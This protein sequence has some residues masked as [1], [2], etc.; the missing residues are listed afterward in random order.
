MRLEAMSQTELDAPLIAAARKGDTAPLE[1][2]IRRHARA[3]ARLAGRLLGNR[4]DAE[5]VVQES[6]TRA[7]LNLEKFREKASFRTW[8]LK[9][10][11]NVATD[12]L[13]KRSRRPGLGDLVGQ[14]TEGPPSPAAG[15]SRRAEA[16]DQLDHLNQALHDLPPRQKTAL[17]LKIYEGLSYAEIASVL[18]TTEGAARVYLTLARQSLRRRFE[19]VGKNP[20]SEMRRG[21]AGE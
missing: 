18:G 12:V 4:E 1:Q 10:T 19:Q 20:P 21:E 17:Q 9:I 6:F 15:P 5:D 13:R 2:L 16:R 8:L 14:G 7:F 3:A 11:L